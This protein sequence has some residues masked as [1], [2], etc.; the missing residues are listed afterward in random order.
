V[1]NVLFAQ[2][3]VWHWRLCLQ[4]FYAVMCVVLLSAGVMWNFV[5]LLCIVIM[6]GVECDEMPESRNRGITP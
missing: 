5:L 3:A 4:V 6:Y 2:M 1:G